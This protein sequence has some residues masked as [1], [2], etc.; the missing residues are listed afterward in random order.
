[1]AEA[2]VVAPFERNV[3]SLVS[4]CAAQIDGRAGGFERGV[5]GRGG[6][7]YD[8]RRFVSSGRLDDS[9]AAPG[10][11]YCS[12]ANDGAHIRFDREIDRPISAAAVR[13]IDPEPAFAARVDDGG[14][15]AAVRRRDVQASSAALG[16]DPHAGGRER[17]EA[18]RG[19]QRSSMRAST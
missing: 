4:G 3:I 14:P 17:I 18:I 19:A 7:S 12:G 13:A 2:S 10:D 8:G 16:F 15:R 6:D 5:R 11:V 9:E 1:A